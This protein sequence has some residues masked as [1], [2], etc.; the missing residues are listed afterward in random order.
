M[1]STDEPY[2]T[3]CHYPVRKYAQR[4]QAEKSHSGFHVQALGSLRGVFCFLVL[5]MCVWYTKSYCLMR[6]KVWE[7][8]RFSIQIRKRD[9]FQ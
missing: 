1:I 5:C 4:M 3:I 7:V 6:M 9:I 2:P 8:I